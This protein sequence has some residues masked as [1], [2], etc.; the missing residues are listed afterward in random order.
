[1]SP[2]SDLH[3][4]KELLDYLNLDYSWKSNVGNK[5]APEELEVD[6]DNYNFSFIFDMDGKFT[7]VFSG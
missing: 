1:M 7:H 5:Y 2:E 6:C 4:V 3:K